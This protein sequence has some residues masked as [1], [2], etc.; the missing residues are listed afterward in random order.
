MEIN[1]KLTESAYDALPL[2]LIP[3]RPPALL[4]P[5]LVL[6]SANYQELESSFTPVV[7]RG[8]HGEL[9]PV[10]DERLGVWEGGE[11]QRVL[12]ALKYLLSKGGGG[13]KDGREGGK[14]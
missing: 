14:E 1:S 11:T 3:P 7:G 6:S 8:W 12:R 5:S 2:C 9:V 4:S 13:K 10:V